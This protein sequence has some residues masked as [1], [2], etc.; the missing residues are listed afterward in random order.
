MLEAAARPRDGC[1]VRPRRPSPTP[2]RVGPLRP[3]AGGPGR[4][5]GGRGPPLRTRTATGTTHR[6]PARARLQRLPGRGLRGSPEAAGAGGF[7]CFFLPKWERPGPRKSPDSP[8]H[9]PRDERGRSGGGRG[10]PGAATDGGPTAGRPPLRVPLPSA[11][12]ASQRRHLPPRSGGAGVS[13]SAAAAPGVHVRGRLQRLHVLTGCARV[14]RASHLCAKQ[15]PFCKRP[16][17]QGAAFKCAQSAPRALTREGCPSAPQ[18]AGRAPFTPL[19]LQTVFWGWCMVGCLLRVGAEAACTR[20]RTRAATL[21]QHP[22]VPEAPAL[23]AWRGPRPAGD[24]LR[25]GG[26]APRPMLSEEA[27]RAARRR[28][29]SAAR[30]RVDAPGSERYGVLVPGRGLRGWGWLGPGFVRR[31][32]KPPPF[33]LRSGGRVVTAAASAEFLEGMVRGSGQPRR[34][35]CGRGA[36]CAELGGTLR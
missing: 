24:W 8:A 29:G 2:G 11:A 3:G 36:L 18:R 10:V 34:D 35:V 6:G 27:G 17:L 21:P 30:L 28:E 22:S 7:P 15:L 19:S 32:W 9:T 13:A 4:R 31:L 14:L 12:G 23:P 1:S 5:A 20:S 25:R 26:P 33:P 16:L